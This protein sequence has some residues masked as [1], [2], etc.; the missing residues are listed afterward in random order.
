M[1]K[2]KRVKSDAWRKPM[3]S[4]PQLVASVFQVLPLNKGFTRP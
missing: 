2:D 3:I 4:Q 1:L